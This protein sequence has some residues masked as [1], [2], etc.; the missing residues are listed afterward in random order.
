MQSTHSES[1]TQKQHN[2]ETPKNKHQNGALSG[3]SG[4]RG[5]LSNEDLNVIPSK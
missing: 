4:T 1:E 5:L 3:Q 2:T